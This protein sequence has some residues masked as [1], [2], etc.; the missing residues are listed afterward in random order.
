MT[1]LPSFLNKL[2][3]IKQIP[4][5]SGLNWF[6]LNRISRRV[7]LVDF[8]K[9]DIV[10]KKGDPADAFYA[11]VSGRIYSYAINTAGQKEDV[12]FILRGMHFGI[13][14]TLTGENHTHTYEAINDSVVVKIDKD[15][16]AILLKSIPKLAVALSQSLS[17][18]IRSHST[19][20]RSTQ[21]CTIISVYAPVKGTGSSTY[22][23]NLALTL[24][25]QTDKKVLLLNLS[26][27]LQAPLTNLIDI[28]YDHQKIL[29]T[30]Q[31]DK[32]SLD[33]L[34]V[35]FDPA[36]QGI[37]PRIGQL[38]SAPVNDYNYIIFDLPNQMDNIVLKALVQSDIVHLM[39]LEREYDLGLTRCVID[40]LS[41]QLKDR[42]QTDKVQVLISGV[43]GNENLNPEEIKK[44][45]NYDVFLKLPSLKPTEF[46][47]HIL[48][49]G[50][51]IIK[52]DI[53]SEYGSVLQRL[54]RQISGSLIGLVLG[55]G[56]ALGLA[57]VGIIRVLEQEKIPIDI[58][59]GSSM[60]ALIGSLWSVGYNAD[61]MEKFAR[62][63]EKK[64]G[65]LSIFDPPFERSLI[66]LFVMLLLVIFHFYVLA[67]LCMFLLVPLALPISGL[68][69]G[70]AISRW[71]WGKLGDRTF[72]DSKIPFKAVAYDL[73][74]REEIVIDTGSLVEAV[75]KSIAIPGVLRPVITADQ[76]II[77]GG[78]LNPLPTNV[79]VDIGVRK[80][81]AVNVLQSPQEVAWS[82]DLENEHIKQ[83]EKIS[84]KV[85]PFQFI[86]FRLTRFIAKAFTPNIAD[87]VVRT[88]QASE[89]ILAEASSK[90]ADV[91][92]HPDL[93]GINWFELYEV[94]K[95]ITR[96][97]E[98][99][100]AHLPSIKALV[101]R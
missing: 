69:R 56:A 60:G 14:S 50:F 96:G 63:F 10:C 84:F 71:L 52:V 18:R 30:I 3:V 88:L 31:K 46:D 99:A 2:A 4:L 73:H 68:V 44:I 35:K 47:S 51:S 41:Q 24:K 62:E 20:I 33:V 43:P 93:K 89:Y 72:H 49:D 79:L 98:A 28:V 37:L 97:Q 45:L 42:F 5:F 15:A 23:A 101:K 54:S 9:G 76:L 87:I 75:H 64:A 61:E 11:V 83:Q 95:L 38:I 55:G 100:A 91:L 77:D 16:F 22:A 29:A 58:I 40:D 86:G 81:I 94:Q 74:R 1:A 6:E 17:Q 25:S 70:Q 59:V 48:F 34:A 78:V 8:N 39:T 32:L 13:I 85:H 19:G 65:M 12:D 26:S 21:E 27:D 80:I 57:H 36:D 7:D 53:H 82:Q 66:V 90:Q 67:F 92:I